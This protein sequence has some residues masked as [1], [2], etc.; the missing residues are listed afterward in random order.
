M[1]TCDLSDII[2]HVNPWSI[3]VV[4][5]CETWR[6][7]L[8]RCNPSLLLPIL[9]QLV[10][11]DVGDGSTDHG[12][13]SLLLCCTTSQ[14]Y[15]R[16]ANTIFRVAPLHLTPSEAAA[17]GLSWQSWLQCDSGFQGLSCANERPL[18]RARC[19]EESLQSLPMNSVDYTR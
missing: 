6:K 3:P 14:G 1:N 19:L 12:L 18:P 7:L 15:S 9:L 17:Q 11:P 8:V 5:T 10:H 2:G 4:R 16:Q 13:V